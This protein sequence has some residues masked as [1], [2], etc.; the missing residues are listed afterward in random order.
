MAIVRRIE[1]W[2]ALMTVEDAAA[3]LSCS[4]R[5]VEALQASSKLIAVKSDAGKRF[6]RAE[7]DRYVSTLPEWPGRS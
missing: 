7:L 2:P 1:G 6:T 4:T 5:K 3:Y